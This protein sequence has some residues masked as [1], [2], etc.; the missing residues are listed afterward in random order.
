MTVKQKATEI[1]NRY[2]KGNELYHDTDR[3]LEYINDMIDFFEVFIDREQM[4][5]YTEVKK[6]FIKLCNIDQS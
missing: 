5:Y 1:Y 3:A 4:Q 2:K 6:E